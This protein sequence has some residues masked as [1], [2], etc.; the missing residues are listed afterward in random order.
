MVSWL[1]NHKDQTSNLLEEQHNTEHR[2][3]S[4]THYSV[5]FHC[6][7][8]LRGFLPPETTFPLLVLIE[9]WSYTLIKAKLQKIHTKIKFSSPTNCIE[10]VTAC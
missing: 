5:S 7:Y 9:L 2:L 10:F 4:L 6:T 3:Q 8:V 1:A